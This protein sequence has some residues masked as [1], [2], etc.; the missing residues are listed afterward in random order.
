MEDLFFSSRKMLNQKVLIPQS[1]LHSVHLASLMNLINE[2]FFD[3]I[4][5]EEKAYLLGFF[6]ADGCIQKEAKKKNGE[7][8]SYNVSNLQFALSGRGSISRSQDEGIFNR[9]VRYLF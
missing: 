1:H 9:F 5:S 3:N 4:D 6:I 2:N 8:Y 7:I